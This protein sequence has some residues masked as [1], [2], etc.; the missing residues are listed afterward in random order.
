MDR[1]PHTWKCEYLKWAM[2]LPPSNLPA[3]K[4]KR[5]DYKE[6]AAVVSKI[7]LLVVEQWSRLRAT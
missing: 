2:K 5:P 1:F 7:P 6:V 3:A 4:Q